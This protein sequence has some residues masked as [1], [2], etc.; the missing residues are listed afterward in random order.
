MLT[1]SQLQIT[2][3]DGKPTVKLKHT[4]EGN[5]KM[6]LRETATQRHTERVLRASGRAKCWE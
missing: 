1:N 4:K 3:C 2:L 6:A 5:I